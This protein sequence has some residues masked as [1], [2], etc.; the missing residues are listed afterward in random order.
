MS[1]QVIKKILITGANGFIGGALMR[2]SKNKIRMLL[3]LILLETVLI[4]SRVI[5]PI[6]TRFLIF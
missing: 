2:H 1:E 3:A 5:L 6:Q 4:L